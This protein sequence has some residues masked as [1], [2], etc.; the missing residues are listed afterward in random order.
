MKQLLFLAKHQL[1]QVEDYLLRPVKLQDS[2]AMFE[3]ASDAK[4]TR[5]LSFNAHQSLEE[6]QAIIA[7]LFMQA[8]LGKW[9]IES[10]KD[11]KMIGTIEFRF[12]SQ[13]DKATFGYVLNADYW[14]KGIMPLILK[15]LIQLIFAE[16]PIQEIYGELAQENVQ[17]ERVMLKCGLVL[18][19][20]FKGILK[21]RNIQLISEYAI[22]RQ[23]YIKQKQ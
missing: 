5:Y 17:S 7:S 8:P 6:T 11:A 14:G 16:L 2:E 4:V 21:N 9:A 3:Y 1:I 10:I 18:K 20:Q 15:R 13:L 22:T 12:A 23:Q 19:R